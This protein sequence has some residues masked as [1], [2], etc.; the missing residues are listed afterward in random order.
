MEL[1]NIMLSERIPLMWNL[2]HKANQKRGKNRE[3]QPRN[4]LNHKGQTDGYQGGGG[5]EDGW[6]IWWGL[7]SARAVMSTGCYMEVLNH[8]CAPETSITLYVNWNLNKNFE[9]VKILKIR[10]NIRWSIEGRVL[11]EQSYYIERRSKM[12]KS[13]WR[14]KKA[15]CIQGYENSSV[16]ME[17]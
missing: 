11:D 5:W 13:H 15:F 4:R 1:E 8:Y 16:W 12:Y 17:A 2:R 10:C 9:K 3:R 7:S 14:L 6:T